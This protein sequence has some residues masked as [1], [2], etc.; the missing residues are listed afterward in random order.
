MEHSGNM[1][2]TFGDFVPD[3]IINKR[4]NDS[5]APAY[6][7]SEG[8]LRIKA[9]RYFI[10]FYFYLGLPSRDLNYCNAI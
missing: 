10:L 6:L 2:G 1:Q 8:G 4:I 5:C 7:P 3:V 9:I